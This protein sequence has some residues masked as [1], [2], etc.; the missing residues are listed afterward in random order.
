D[1]V[2][3]NEESQITA[4]SIYVT[5]K[6][7]W[8]DQMFTRKNSFIISEDSIQNYNQVK[9]RDMLAHFAD[10]QLY[11]VDVN[12]NGESIYFA[13]EENTNE[14]MGMNKIICSDM[15]IRLVDNKVDNI[16]SYTNPDGK[17]VPTH[18]IVDKE[19][20]LSGFTWRIEERPELWQ[21]LH[22]SK[23]E[24]LDMYSGYPG[25]RDT[26]DTS[27]QDDPGEQTEES[28]ESEEAKTETETN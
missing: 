3:W 12:G 24:F 20:Q 1:P 28:N 6:D 15:K 13:L 18:E 14:L 22:M 25:L 4:D 5:I 8:I 21:V 10:N 9:G 7:G 19:K 26:E 11:L 2:L 16:T 23:E 27:Q 17:F